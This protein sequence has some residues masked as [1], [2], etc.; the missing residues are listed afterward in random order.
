MPCTVNERG[1]RGAIG[2]G[3]EIL[4][5]LACITWVL[6]CCCGRAECHIGSNGADCQSCRDRASAAP[7]LDRLKAQVKA[8]RVERQGNYP[9]KAGS[10]PHAGGY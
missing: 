4:E 9:E 1:R 6:V 10:A 3:A 5:F 7:S 2:G 8:Y